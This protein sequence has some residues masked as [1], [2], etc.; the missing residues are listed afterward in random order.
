MVEADKETDEQDYHFWRIEK[1][2]AEGSYEIP[3]GTYLFLFKIT[4][5]IHDFGFSVSNFLFCAGEAV[6]L[7]YNLVGLNAISFDKG[8]YVGQE[9]VARSH[10]RG[11]I[12]KRLAPLMFL[13]NDRKGNISKEAY[14][15]IS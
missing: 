13:K 11:V 3:K 9:L 2:V 10:H 12:R 14:S 8:C 1:G 4:T 7:E 5:S 6:P 15:F